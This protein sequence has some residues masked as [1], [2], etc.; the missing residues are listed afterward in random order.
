MYSPY[1]MES[2]VGGWGDKWLYL[3]TEFVI[4]PSSGKGKGRGKG[5]RKG[6]VHEPGDG[7]E[8]A[9]IA[10]TINN[11][12]AGPNETGPGLLAP[13]L[14]GAPESNGSSPSP[15][16]SPSPAQGA[17]AAEKSNGTRT[18]G[19]G[20]GHERRVSAVTAQEVKMAALRNRKPRSDGGVVCCLAVSEYCFKVGR[21]TV[22]P[23]SHGCRSPFPSVLSL[24]TRPG[25][26]VLQRI[27]LFGALLSPT[28]DQ[29]DRADR[30]LQAG[31]KQAGQWLKGGWK[32]EPDADTIGADIGLRREEGAAEKGTEWI[33]RGRDGM[34]KVVEGLGVF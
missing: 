33:N 24:I 16:P 34:D 1:V 27:A 21:V 22:P 9:G 26:M 14:A 7:A 11:Q 10:A 15:S 6:G 28:Q 18:Q 19:Q 2:R 25:L 30:L 8:S 20:Q 31:R 13:V 23:V 17:G 4:F 29:R 12:L 5:T 3:V 32:D